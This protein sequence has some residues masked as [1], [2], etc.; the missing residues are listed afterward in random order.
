MSHVCPFWSLNDF[1]CHAPILRYTAGMILKAAR[2]V[3]VGRDP[4]RAAR[5]GLIRAI[6][7]RAPLPRRGLTGL[8]LSLF[9]R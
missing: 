7:A 9:L 1:T 5:R 3:I 6:A 2:L 8:L 4:Q